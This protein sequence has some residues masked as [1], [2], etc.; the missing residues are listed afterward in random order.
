MGIPYELR[1]AELVPWGRLMKPLLRQAFYGEFPE[2]LLYRKKTTL[3][4]GSHV[5]RIVKKFGQDRLNEIYRKLFIPS[6]KQESI[7]ELLL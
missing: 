7:Q 6:T 3:Q 5:E 1:N 2:E 4:Q